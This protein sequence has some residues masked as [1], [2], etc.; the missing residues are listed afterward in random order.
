M[1]L[2]TIN[3]TDGSVVKINKDKIAWV[4]EVEKDKETGEPIYE[5]GLPELVVRTKDDIVWLTS[6]NS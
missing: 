4:K 5:I 6:L 2:T 3:C 1:K